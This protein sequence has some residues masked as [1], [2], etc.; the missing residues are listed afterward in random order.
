M[1]LLTEF[2]SSL[3]TGQV[4]IL[5]FQKTVVNYCATEEKKTFKATSLFYHLTFR[6]EQP[7]LESIRTLVQIHSGTVILALHR[8]AARHVNYTS[9][10]TN[11]DFKIIL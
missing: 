5:L 3:Y 8:E 1:L 9:V 7:T 11:M 4:C 10:K 6:G 2:S